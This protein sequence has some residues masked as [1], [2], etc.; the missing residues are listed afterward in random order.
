MARSIAQPRNRGRR[1]PPQAENDVQS[2]QTDSGRSALVGATRITGDS[3]RLPI[4][5]LRL[6]NWQFQSGARSTDCHTG[7]ACSLSAPSAIKGIQHRAW[8]P[9]SFVTVVVL[10]PKAGSVQPPPQVTSR[11]T[12]P[13]TG[14]EKGVVDNPEPGRGH[15][16]IGQQPIQI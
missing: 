15:L 10:E 8:E 11:F 2:R 6:P 4:G 5:M 13:E 1:P 9:Q 16:P 7:N 3:R 12:S 14:V